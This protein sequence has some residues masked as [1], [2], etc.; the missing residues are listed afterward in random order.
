MAAAKLRSIE[1]TEHFQSGQ[2]LTI[3]AEKGVITRVKVLG[4]HSV[5]G[6]EYPPATQARAHSML[7]GAKVNIDHRARPGDAAPLKSRFAILRGITHE[8]DDTFGNLHFN[9]K[10]HMAEEIAWWAKN[11][12]SALGLSINAHGKTRRKAGKDVVESIDVVH[13]VD[14]VGD[15]ATTKGLFEQRGNPM[16]TTVKALLEKIFAKDAKKLKLLREEFPA[17]VTAAPMDAPADDG[18]DDTGGNPDDQ[19]A[20]A[21]RAMVEAVLDDDSLD[22]AAKIKKIKNILVTEEKLTGANADDSSS[23][24]ST[25][26]SDST[27]QE[28]RKPVAPAGSVAELKEEL[29]VRDLVEEAGIKFAKPEG[30]R[31]F[32]RAL[33][34]LTAQERDALIE[35]KKQAGD[36]GITDVGGGDGKG[37]RDLLV[38][39][40]STPIQEQRT[41]GLAFKDNKSRLSFMRSGRI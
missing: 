23:G 4:R 3:D 12:P 2:G 37:K 20:A 17:D 18:S 32:V 27:A 31:A 25:S 5:N 39:S 30:R 38:R 19:I 40:G 13:S 8:G 9:P 24:D 26:G 6:R 41:V 11:E 1:L 10:H 28:G 36:A 7:E 35:E 21:F 15:P 16:K 33:V 29:A 22:I 34:P 14:L